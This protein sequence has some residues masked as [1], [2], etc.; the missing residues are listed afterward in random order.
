VD[1]IDVVLSNFGMNPATYQQGDLNGDATVNVPDV[2]IAI[3]NPNGAQQS[4]AAAG[5]GVDC[6]Q[7]VIDPVTGE[8]KCV[9]PAG[10]GG[11]TGGDKNGGYPPGSLCAAIFQSLAQMPAFGEAPSSWIGCFLQS[12]CAL[13]DAQDAAKK[14]LTDQRDSVIDPLKAA[15]TQATANAQSIYN[16]TVAIAAN[17]RRAHR[18]QIKKSRGAVA[19]ITVVLWVATQQYPAAEAALV[20]EYVEYDDAMKNADIDFNASVAAADLSFRSDSALTAAQDALNTTG[21]QA[22][23]TYESECLT[24]KQNHNAAMLAKCQACDQSFQPAIVGFCN[25]FQNP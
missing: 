18:H 20:A 13:R 8:F 4:H 1:Q 19:F 3:T 17:T 22:Q 14:A 23:S 15:L 12:T 25:K 11:R 9:D 21:A 6:L 16:R 7:F 5:G 24:L 10:G 2:I